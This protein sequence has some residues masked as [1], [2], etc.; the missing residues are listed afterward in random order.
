HPRAR[1]PARARRRAR[2]LARALARAR[3]LDAAR[4]RPQGAAPPLR[5]AMKRLVLLVALLA[6]IRSASAHAFDPMLVEV[7]EDA[8]GKVD[9]RVHAPPSLAGS[10]E[11]VAPTVALV[12]DGGSGLR[13]RAITLHGLDGAHEAVLRVTLRDGTELTSVLHGDGDRFDIPPVATARPR[14]RV[15]RD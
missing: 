3:A 1:R 11:F 8:A 9:V 4:T 13:G 2:A 15:L 10:A 6:P 7:R 5:G 14:A 12:P